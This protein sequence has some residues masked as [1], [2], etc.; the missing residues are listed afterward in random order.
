MAEE[1]KD[2][3]KKVEDTMAC[4]AYAEEGEP[5]PIDTGE[6]TAKAAT[7]TAKEKT[8]LESVEKDFACTAFRDEN[9]ECP[10]NNDKK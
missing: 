6:G 2:T 8:T 9:Q 10:P 7:G 1:K 3:L 4:S 5:C